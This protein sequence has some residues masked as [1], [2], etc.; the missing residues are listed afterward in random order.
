[1]TT[2]SLAPT[3]R[4]AFA[5]PEDVAYFNTANLSPQ[6]HT[7]R[8]AGVA[9]LDRRGQPWTIG[10]A[11]WFT[12]VERLRALAGAL[13]GADAEGIALVPSTSY[14]FAV[15]ARVLDVR[16]GDRVLVLAEEYPSGIY[17]WRAAGADLL[18]VG[19]NPGGTWTDAV[20]AALD[21]RVDVVSVPPVH[22]T[23]G[24]RVD[25]EAVAART[26]EVGARLVIDG[27][28]AIGAM[29]FDVG[30]LHPDAVVTVGYKWLLGP[31]G[32]GY[33]YLAPEHRDG[34]PI[35][36]NWI[37]RE[38]SEDF[39]RLVDYRDTYQPGTRRF[40]VGERSQFEL[41]PMAIAALEQIT[42]WGVERIAASLATTTGAVRRRTADLGLD[43]GRPEDVGPHVLG[44]RLPES[45][46]GGVLGALAAAGV[47]ASVRGDALRV[48]PHLHVTDDD[49]DRLVDALATC[50]S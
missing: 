18:T 42:A 47:Y 48:A 26:R 2:D 6:L 25:L 27:S 33:L 37:L 46:R 11:D 43:A 49:I 41:V 40:D 16:P 34:A 13:V 23:D 4:A 31:F 24:A 44:L 45:A 8:A 38:G 1:M 19:R 10:A 39:A 32:L 28:Q 7:V 50:S 17:T 21:E 9:A 15:T 14:G 29:P 3:G 30:A 20:L 35:E 36:Q 22:W 12:D 5:V